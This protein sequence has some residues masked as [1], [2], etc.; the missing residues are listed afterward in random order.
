MQGAHQAFANCVHGYD[1][2]QQTA[3]HVHKNSCTVLISPCKNN[4]NLP[5]YSSFFYP[6][7]GCLLLSFM[8]SCSLPRCAD[9]FVCLFLQKPTL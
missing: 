9:F 1:R 3:L 8:L 2:V 7:L 4:L 5:M 6:V